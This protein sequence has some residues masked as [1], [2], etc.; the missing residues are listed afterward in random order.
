MG[1]DQFA[2]SR[3]R[4]QSARLNDDQRGFCRCGQIIS[5]GTRHLSAAA[6]HQDQLFVAEHRNGRGFIRQAAAA[7]LGIVQVGAL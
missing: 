1:L 2:E 5:G 3:R 6:A 7:D 4:T